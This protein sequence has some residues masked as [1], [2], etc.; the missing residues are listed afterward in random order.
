VRYI[1]L[2]GVSGADTAEKKLAL[3]LTLSHEGRDGV[4]DENNQAETRTAVWA[5][6]EMT[7][8]MLKDN[9]TSSVMKAAINGSENLQKD[10]GAYM[11]AKMKGDDTI[12]DKYVDGTYDSSADYWKLIYDEDGNSFLEY[13]GLADIYDTN[14]NFLVGAGTDREKLETAL[15]KY[16]GVS[17]DEAEKILS[18]SEFV[19]KNNSWVT[20]ENKGKKISIG[21]HTSNEHITDYIYAAHRIGLI[22]ELITFTLSITGTTAEAK[23]ILTAEVEGADKN[24]R[25]IML[26]QAVV[27]FYLPDA[28]MFAG[29]R[30]SLTTRIGYDPSYPARGTIHKGNDYAAERGTPLHTVFSGIVKEISNPD[31]MVFESKEAFDVSKNAQ[32]KSAWVDTHHDERKDADGNTLYLRDQNPRGNGVIIEHG[33]NLN[34]NF[35]SMGFSTRSNHFDYV[36]V[37]KDEFV[38]SNA[39]IGLLGNSGWST[40]T[41]VDYNLYFQKNTNNAIYNIYQL[42]RFGL[43]DDEARVLSDVGGYRYVD[44]RGIYELYK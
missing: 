36:N 17:E 15:S 32:E 38:P 29:V 8:R 27:D 16:L 18:A 37:A 43:T 24:D 42:G 26:R 11:T 35:L 20:D 3:A 40:G 1:T 39:V 10:L 9:A 30:S 7:L 25:Y 23:R 33:F 41:H 14:G 34:G 5:H 6:T 2:N 28:S 12:F 21:R 4:V 13:D 19:E 44:P 22:K 31:S